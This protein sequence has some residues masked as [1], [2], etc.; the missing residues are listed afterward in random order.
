MSAH[1]SRRS[2]VCGLALAVGLLGLAVLATLRAQQSTDRGRTPKGGEVA[3]YITAS[4]PGASTQVV[5]ETVTTPLEQALAGLEGRE[6]VESISKEGTC[7]ITAYF[8]AGEDPTAAQTRVQRAV[9]GA[10]STLSDAVRSLKPVVRLW[11]AD[12]PALWLV[13]RSN[14]GRF[15]LL[16]LHNF[17]TIRLAPE[18]AALPGVVAVLPPPEVGPRLALWLDP[19]KLAA[20]N[21]SPGDVTAALRK[22]KAG[23]P[24]DLEST[25]LRTDDGGAVVLLRDVARLEIGAGGLEQTAQGYPHPSIGLAVYPRREDTAGQVLDEV[26]CRLGDL[27]KLLPEGASLEVVPG[28]AAPGVEALMIEGRLPDSAS[29]ERVETVVRRLSTSLERGSE[30][31]REM[32]ALPTDPPG[33]H[34]YVPLAPARK[35]DPTLEEVR[36]RAARLR[37]ETPEAMLRVDVAPQRDVPPRMRSAATVAVVDLQDRGLRELQEQAETVV[38]LL[39]KSPAVTEVWAVARFNVPQIDISIDSEKARK[40]GVAKKDILDTLQVYYG[41]SLDGPMKGTL[42]VRLAPAF[43]FNPDDVKGLKVRSSTGE[44]VPLGAL[45]TIRD[46]AG[47]ESI[48]H[49]D[50]KRCVLISAQPPAGVTLE[51]ARRRCREL[52][53]KD[54]VPA[55][56]KVELLDPAPRR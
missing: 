19:D 27:R 13:L 14:E 44:M 4:Y 32:L 11:N 40:V 12:W 23:K 6:T 38:Q 30:R 48:R 50:G 41:L 31:I 56:Y 21:L 25:V 42:Q 37:E 26:R 10:L 9:D 45:V 46:V 43:R 7:T 49:L 53:H 54:V 24:E 39:S 34:L 20:R 17:A 55:A 28:P 29:R 35:G 3:V 52:L 2:V 15:D 8:R 51:E 5:E 33:F 1:V 18:V 36:S 22:A 16:Y 47:P